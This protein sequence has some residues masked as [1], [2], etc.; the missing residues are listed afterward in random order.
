MAWEEMSL[1]ELAELG[2]TPSTCYAAPDGPRQI[3]ESGGGSSS[4]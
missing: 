3:G 4:S 2:I 1:D